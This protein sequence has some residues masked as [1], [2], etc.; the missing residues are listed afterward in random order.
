VLL[1]LVFECQQMF[2]GIVLEPARHL[3]AIQRAVAG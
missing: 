2:S 3:V 1:A